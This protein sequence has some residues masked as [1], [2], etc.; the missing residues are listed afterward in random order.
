MH[1]NNGITPVTEFAF[2]DPRLMNP[3]KKVKFDGWKL[4]KC[5]FLKAKGEYDQLFK[6]DDE[7][8]YTKVSEPMLH[9]GR[10]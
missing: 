2:Y 1:N 5:L 6:K 4:E 8:W 7:P 10:Q 3:K 9:A